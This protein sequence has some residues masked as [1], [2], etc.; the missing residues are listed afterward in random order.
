MAGYPR[1]DD[2]PPPGTDRVGH[3]ARLARHQ[4][5]YNSAARPRQ[6]DGPGSAGRG[7]PPIPAAGPR[8]LSTSARRL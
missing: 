4:I 1:P 3:S 6:P 5:A 2:L 8:R 7:H